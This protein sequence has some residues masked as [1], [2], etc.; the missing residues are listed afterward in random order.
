M[1]WTKVAMLGKLF[2]H[3]L[4]RIANV[5]LANGGPTRGDWQDC[6]SAEHIDAHV[7]PHLENHAAGDDSEPHLDHAA[8]RLLMALETDSHL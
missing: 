1:K 3:A 5:I 6:P 4:E 8:T 7:L 2:P